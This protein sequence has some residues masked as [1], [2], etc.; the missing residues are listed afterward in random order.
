MTSE[1][2]VEVASHQAEVRPDFSG[3]V[4]IRTGAVLPDVRADSG[5]WIGVEIAL[6]KTDV[7]SI[8]ALT[9][10]YAA[11][12]GR[13]EGQVDVVRRAVRDMAVD[14]LARGAALAT[15]PLL[16]WVAVGRRRRRELLT[17]LPT[18]RGAAGAVVVVLV[19]VGLTAPW[20]GW[21]GPSEGRSEDWISLGSYLGPEVDLPE[22]AAGIDV[23]TDATTGQT[24]R[25][26]ESAIS[27][28]QLGREF[29][30]DAATEAG[31]LLELRQPEEGETVVLVVSDRHD[32][33]GMDEVAKA[34]G[35]TAGATAVFDAGDDTSTGESWEA[36]SLDSLAAT[37]RDY[38]ERWAVAGNH[39]NGDF[40]RSYL[41]DLGWSYFDGEV[42]E[43]PGGARLLGV[44]DPRSSGLGNWRDESGL[45][46]D[47]VRTRLA[48]AACDADDDGDRV[49]TLLVHDPNLGSE[50]LDRGCVDLVLGGHTHVQ[51]GP[52]EVVGENGETGYTFTV[53]TTGGAAYAIAIGSKLRRPAGVALVTYDDGRPVGIQGV[54]LQTTGRFDVT[55]YVSLTY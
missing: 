5:S 29:Y 28:Y 37:F 19:A 16:V 13:P 43:G 41:E 49:S 44:D 2:T 51:D 3:R 15:V 54:T 47:E 7:A 39:D 1:R 4:V 36:F 24:R 26:I 10:R 11:I 46:F 50:A 9:Q 32:N 30:A 8:E 42:V 20:R 21:D 22:E 53:G 27:T 52:T 25:L 23:L 34:V 17:A 12:A 38:E 35:D 40:V 55:P 48:D 31:E 18:R 6:G 45:S 14:A 33:I